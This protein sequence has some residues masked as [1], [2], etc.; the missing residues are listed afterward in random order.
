MR[1]FFLKFKKISIYLQM[2]SIDYVQIPNEKPEIAEEAK[3]EIVIEESFEERKEK[4]KAELV[5]QMSLSTDG[6]GKINKNLQ[7]SLNSLNYLQL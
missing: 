2:W 3:E 6:G 5:K 1:R 4:K 7:I